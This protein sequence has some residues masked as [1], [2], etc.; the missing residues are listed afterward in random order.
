MMREHDTVPAEPV[1]GQVF[2][3]WCG[4]T[5]TFVV[6]DDGQPGEWV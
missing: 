3:C 2:T 6:L 5:A 4:D 1:D